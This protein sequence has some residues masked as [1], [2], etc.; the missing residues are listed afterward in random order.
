MTDPELRAYLATRPP[1]ESAFCERLREWY[2]GR[3]VSPSD[4]LLP[5][6]IVACGPQTYDAGLRMAR[7]V[8]VLREPQGRRVLDIGAGFG[9]A[10]IGFARAG[11]FSVGLDINLEELTMA[12]DRIAAHRLSASLVKGSAFALPFRD[13][14]FDVVACAEVLEHVRQRETLLAEAVRVL[15]RGGVLYL[16]FPNLLSI[17]NVLNDPH[18]QLFGVVLL[19]L[20]LARRYTRWRRG[21]DY[22]VEILPPAPAIARLCAG[23]G[24]PVYA[25]NASERVLLDKM[26]SP[27]DIRG[28]GRHLFVALKKLGLTPLVRAAIRTYS[29]FGAGAVLAGV[30]S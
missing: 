14:S 9:G 7:E 26:E 16:S 22:E 23:L 25:V 4:P 13:E 3:G 6:W 5:H 1:A 12:A 30:K 19:P 21:H 2:L 8:S 10:L 24:V 28:R 17:R 18:Y 29:A 27:Q 20:A 15:R 11:A